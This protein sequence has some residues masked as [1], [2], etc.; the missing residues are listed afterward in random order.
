MECVEHTSLLRGVEGTTISISRVNEKRSGCVIDVLLACEKSND[1]MS[2]QYSAHTTSQHK[3]RRQLTT[4]LEKTRHGAVEPMR[5]LDFMK[6]RWNSSFFY[7]NML[8]KYWPVCFESRL[9][10]ST[11]RSPSAFRLDST[12]ISISPPSSSQMYLTARRWP[13][14]YDDVSTNIHC[15]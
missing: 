7:I 10:M 1:V 12:R 8:Q 4:D 15:V 6:C 9:A 2:H 5:V 13:A 11:A 3:W 14:G